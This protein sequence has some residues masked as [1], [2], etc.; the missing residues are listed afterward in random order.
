MLRTFLY[1]VMLV[2]TIL[3]F[4]DV[5]Y[6]L[7]RPVTNLPTTVFIITSLVIIIGVVL[8]VKRFIGTVRLGQFMAFFI[9]QAVAFLFN[10]VFVS[11]TVPL[12][13]DVFEMI[14]VGSFLDI[15]ID[16]FAIYLCGKQR[17][18][19]LVTMGGIQ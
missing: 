10:I 11:V 2:T 14:A 12:K 3:R 5:I 9:I 8:I 6:L 17:R 1:I 16:I 13:I 4:A 18:K 19:R 7:S 15:L